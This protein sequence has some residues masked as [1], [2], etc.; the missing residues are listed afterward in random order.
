LTNIYGKARNASLVEELKGQLRSL[1]QYYQDDSDIS[2]P[3][4]QTPTVAFFAAR[5]PGRRGLKE[6]LPV[7]GEPLHSA[8][9]H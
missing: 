4:T 2:E 6:S 8:Q 9:T 1:Q 3:P 5:A 7:P